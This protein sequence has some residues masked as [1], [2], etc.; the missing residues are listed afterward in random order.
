[1][2]SKILTWLLVWLAGVVVVIKLFFKRNTDETDVY[3]I[4]SEADE[5]DHDPVS[6]IIAVP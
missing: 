4:A 5:P 1:M 6:V 3:L 2:M